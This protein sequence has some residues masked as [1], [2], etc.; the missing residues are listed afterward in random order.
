MRFPLLILFLENQ[1]RVY[2]FDTPTVVFP[3]LKVSLNLFRRINS[4]ETH[5]SVGNNCM[6]KKP[7]TVLHCPVRLNAMYSI[8]KLIRAF[9]AYVNL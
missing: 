9:T 6:C 4:H 2:I 8:S 1:Y 5:G 7:L 3:L